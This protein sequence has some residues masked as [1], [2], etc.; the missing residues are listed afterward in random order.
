MLLA[1][2]AQQRQ[3]KKYN[4]HLYYGGQNLNNWSFNHNQ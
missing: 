4:S 3:P 1:S 2:T